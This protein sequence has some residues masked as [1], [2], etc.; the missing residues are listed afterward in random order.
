MPG[1]IATTVEQSISS[2]I[3]DILLIAECMHEPEIR[4]QMVVF[5]PFR[6]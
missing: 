3:D 6:G 1:I 5:L 4:D 2:A